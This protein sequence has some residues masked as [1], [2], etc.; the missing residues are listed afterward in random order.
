MS[1][2]DMYE[3]NFDKLRVIMDVIIPAQARLK[4]DKHATEA[5]VLA[6]RSA[7]CIFSLHHSDHVFFN[8]ELL[9]PVHTDLSRH[10][11]FRCRQLIPLSTC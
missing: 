9:D 10:F 3:A 5:H 11:T 2:F 4:S 6:L 8:F 1:F 7:F